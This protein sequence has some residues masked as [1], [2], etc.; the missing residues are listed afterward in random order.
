MENNRSN[1]NNNIN[2]NIDNNN[3]INNYN[4]KDKVEFPKRLI[5]RILIIAPVNTLE[6]WQNEYNKWIPSELIG[7]VNV[8]I[9]SSNNDV[10]GNVRSDRLF[11]I[12]KWYNDGGILIIGYELFSKMTLGNKFDV[13]ILED[14]AYTE[15]LTNPGI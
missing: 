15:Y 3:E 1:S 12:K 9:I 2:N 13:A 10:V 7:V 4:I 11:K 5:K 6:N 14:N 8:S